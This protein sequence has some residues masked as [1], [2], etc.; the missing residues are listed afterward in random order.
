M[1]KYCINVGI[2]ILADVAEGAN[3]NELLN[4]YARLISNNGMQYT[5]LE[6]VS[7]AEV[8]DLG[9]GYEIDNAGEF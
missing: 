3:V 9:V 7:N 6:G 2:C 5:Q 8:C 4:E 1:A